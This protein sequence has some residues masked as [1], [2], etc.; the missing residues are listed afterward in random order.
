[1]GV[2]IPVSWLTNCVRLTPFRTDAPY[3]LYRKIFRKGEENTNLVLGNVSAEQGAGPLRLPTERLLT[4]K[5][6]HNP[7][8]SS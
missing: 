6:A 2:V 8:I 7:E 4:D 3:N 1:M 5:R